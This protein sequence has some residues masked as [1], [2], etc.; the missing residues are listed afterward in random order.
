M[1][2]WA[3]LLFAAALG[4]VAV[5]VGA[6]ETK[7]VR[8]ETF[9][10]FNQGESTGTE[11]LAQG[12]LQIA[13]RAKRLEKT[14]EG[15]AWRVAADRYDGH[16]FY[17]TGHDGKVYHWFDGK[18][19]LWAD[20]S[21]VE[22]ISL[23]VDPTGAV[24]VGAS[25]GGK[26][27]RVAKANK[28]ELFFDTDEQ[29][30]WDMIFDRDGVLYAATGPDGKIYRIRG[31]NNGEVLFDSDA[32]NVMALNFDPNGKLIAATQG[33]AYVLR[34][35]APGKAYVMYASSEDEARALAVD[36]SGNIFVAVNSARVSSVLDKDKPTAASTP[37]SST[38]MPG[39]IAEIRPASGT[40]T[41]GAQPFG[42]PTGGQSYV[43]QIRPGGFVQTLW[44]A[45]EGPIQS[46]L[47]DPAGNGVL[48]AAGNKGKIYRFQSD[49][50]YSVVADVEEGAVM[51]FAEHKGTI[52]FATAN[53]ASL[54][55]LVSGPTVEGLFASRALNAG[56]TVR[57]GN[58]YY[59][60]EE[61]TGSE[62]LIETRTGNT[63]EPE[64][65]TWSEWQAAK[66]ISPR[67]L[68]S[69]SPVAQY[70]QYRLTMRAPAPGNG[71]HLDNV[72]IFYVQMNA[73]PVIR[74][75]RVEKLGGEPSGSGEMAMQISGSQRPSTGVSAQPTPSSGT[76]GMPAELLA[77]LGAGSRPATMGTPAADSRSQMPGSRLTGSAV[78]A[79][80][81]SQRYGISWSVSDPNGD[82]MEH[83]LFFKGEDE[84]EWK[85]LEKDLTTPR[86]MFS[87]EAIPDGKYRV[88]VEVTDA[89]ANPDTVASTVTLVS[90]IF[91][92][93]NTPPE[94][95]NLAGR[96]VGPNEYEITA[97]AKDATSI[98]SAGEY[99]IDA[100][101]EWKDVLPEDG[102][103]DFSS[104]T[105]RFRAKPE[106]DSREHT[107]S[108][109]V[110][111]R[112]GNSRVE[113]V[114][115]K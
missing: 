113:K 58:I 21:E 33:K 44:P 16:V 39:V 63:P 1:R 54:Y 47:T 4:M 41:S 43:V 9:S 110:F 69:E 103:F 61:T 77:A 62:I 114:L 64:D 89:P 17:C 8:D 72:Q 25:P 83:R 11:L 96:K 101:K 60:A 50:N 29:Y 98:L 51:S 14:E 57:W 84:A 27:Y 38:P 68:T 93:D 36:N 24:L 15:V 23:A 65:K 66:R 82:R 99:N 115:L 74:E 108:L 35:E 97:T 7:V 73:P 42:G 92:V 79:P 95:Q 85:L 5:P 106:K 10:E 40:G 31:Q 26:I 78:G 48:V 109:R 71:P 22:A 53:K 3:G 105:F 111:D 107:I 28:P 91:E 102:I 12:R 75:I 13:P 70:L 2:Y 112:E 45:P 19:E 18:N 59:Q 87:T 52:F 88:K 81:N 20:L 34:V 76:S 30:I 55:Q 80:E 56:S 86:F 94:I 32:T 67:I 104:E 37:A 46:M 90:R 100:A 6:V 49:T